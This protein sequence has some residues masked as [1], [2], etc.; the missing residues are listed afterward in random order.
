MQVKVASPQ[1][2]FMAGVIIKSKL[3]HIYETR[4][5]EYWIAGEPGAAFAVEVENLGSRLEVLCSIDGRNTLKDEEASWD[6]NTGLV[7]PAYGRYKFAVWRQDLDGGREFVFGTDITDSVVSQVGGDTSNAG[8]IGLASWQEK[9]MQRPLPPT[10]D[11]YPTTYRMGASGQS[12]TA[13]SLSVGNEA[14]P[15]ASASAGPTLDMN[16]DMSTSIG[17]YKSDH[18]GTTSFTRGA[19]PDILLIRY[20]SLEALKAAGIAVY[21]GPDAFPGSSTSPASGYEQLSSPKK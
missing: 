13:G 2:S 18:L 4:P 11:S 19:G 20:A 10:Y 3:A 5:G 8:V 15:V 16:M 17:A 6:K 9:R 1:G 14:A 7:I 21:H 12:V